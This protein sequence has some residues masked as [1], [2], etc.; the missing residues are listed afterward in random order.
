MAKQSWTV[1]GRIL[2]RPEFPE[3]KEK[4]GTPIPL[5]GVRVQVSARES[6][7]D[8]TWDSWGDVHVGPQGRFSIREEK[9]R[10]PRYFRVRVMFKDDGLKLYPPSKGVL[11][12]LSRLI[13]GARVVTKLA[14][15]ALETVLS[16]T[17]RLTYDVDWFTVFQD[18]DRKARKGPGTV[19]LGDLVFRPDGAHDLGNRVAR[20]H[21]DIWW[22]TKKLVAVLDSIG[23]GFVA[24]RP[25]AVI[26]PFDNP[27][28]GDGVESSY[29]NPH[30]GIVHLI[31][32]S[33]KDH[34][35][36]GSL[37]HE[38]MHLWAYQH[39]T[40]EDGLAWQLLLH[41]STHEG[42][43]NKTWV[44]F[45]EG[46][47]E[48]ASNRIYTEIYGRPA[49]IYGDVDKAKGVTLDNRAV[50]FSR[51]FLRDTGVKALS[52]LD[53]YEYG[54]IAILT[55]L[56]SD[57]L[58]LL[59]PDA[60]LTWAA[61][62]GSRTWTAG[63]LQGRSGLP[64]LAEVLRGFRTDASKG[65]PKVMRRSEMTRVD[66]LKRLRALSPIVTEERT[67]LVN[68]LLNTAGRPGGIPSKT[69]RPRPAPTAPTVL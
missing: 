64:G 59:D 32:N 8:P 33:R 19:E 25:L 22:Y 31:E 6:K 24:R 37:G 15:E 58:E 68:R 42:R 9:D 56:V 20:R 2:F 35:N 23:C 57:G 45:H 11:A 53:H 29:A 41:G 17:T 43:Q 5:P 12:E 4:Y 48:W 67:A 28:I 63:R 51:R 47:A 38:L 34:F 54:W 55:A 13:P 16:H 30:T 27:L 50:P 40:G 10:T 26:H 60:D 62:P 44:A 3:T 18:E 39:S 66:F 36:P 52:D 14:A 7:L 21:A 1:K 61:F 49:T 65:Y 69:S 46:F